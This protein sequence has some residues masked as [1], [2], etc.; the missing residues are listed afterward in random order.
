MWELDHKE[1]WVPK[2]WCFW[3]MVLE[4]ALGSPLDWRRINQLVLK[5]INPECSLEW[6]T[7]KLKLQYYGP[8]MQKTL[9]CKDPDAK[10]DWRQ[11]EKKPMEDEMVGWQHWLHGHEFE[12]APGVGGGGGS[13]ACCSPWGGRELDMTEQLSWTEQ[14][15]PWLVDLTFQ[16]SVQCYSLQ[17]QILHSP[18]ETSTTGFYFHFDSASS[19]FL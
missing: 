9:I 5:D 10:N 19:F 6:L 18:P 4:K 12:Q 16:V 7:V 2:N 11:E 8:L 3:T 13:L 17:H 14:T 1:S 15:F